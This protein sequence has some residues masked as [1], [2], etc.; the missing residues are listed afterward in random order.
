MRER[1]LE[2]LVVGG[3][4]LLMLMADNIEWGTGWTWP[5]PDLVI[6][7]ENPATDSPVVYPAVQT[8]EFRRPS[9][10]G[11]DIGY[12]RADAVDRAEFQPPHDAAG[13]FFNPPSTPVVAARAGVIWSVDKSARGI[14][15]VIDH[16]KAPGGGK[17]FATYYQHLAAV[18]AG[19]KKG[20]QVLAGTVIGTM[21][22]DPTDPEGFR[23]LHFAV[24]HNGSGDAA[25]V[26]P[27]RAMASWARTSWDARATKG[28]NV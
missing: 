16:G 27:E 10:M 17:G 22:Y 18:T 21:G 11:V 20:D 19:L 6:G 23:H 1:D 7:A 8:Q 15:V 24:W 25:S 13:P 5:V 3:L 12:R 28:T 4:V 14:E 26:D 2:L 9:H